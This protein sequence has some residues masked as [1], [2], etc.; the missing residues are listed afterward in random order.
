LHQA[1]EAKE[2]VVIERESQTYAS[3]TFQNY[4]RMY[5]KIAGM[6]GTGATSE[7]EF[8]SVYNLDVV[9]I[10][11][12]RAIARI[13]HDDLIFQTEAGKFKAI[14]R[15][16]KEKFEKG[17]PVL[18]GTTSIEVN[19]RLSAALRAAGVTHEMLNAKNH[20]REGE[21]IAQAGKMKGV[22][23]ATNMAGRGVDV[24]LGGNPAPEAL[25]EGVKEKGGLF[26]IGTER[27]DARRID[28]QLRGRAG[29]QGDPGETQFFVSLE[30]KLMRMFAAETVKGMMGRLGIPEDEPIQS[31]LV[32]R[33]LESAQEKIE[34]V[35]FD[36]RKHILGFDDVLNH[37][38]TIIY[39]KR[40]AVL[41][42]SYEEIIATATE[43]LTSAGVDP[44]IIV[45]KEEELGREVF[46]TQLR[47][48]LLQ[49]YDLFW[50]EHLETMEYLRGSVNLR[51][52]GGRDPFIEYR[53]EGLRLFRELETSLATFVADAI[54]RMAPQSAAPQS[55]GVVVV[56]S[57]A[58]RYSRNDHVTI[59]NGTETKELK[60]KKAEEFLSKGWRI[61]A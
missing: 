51:S 22:T 15:T 16:A 41:S 55:T 2:G 6:T 28:N 39:A 23:V 52:F 19:E 7:E 27:H 47:R 21:I 9:V 37:Q 10:P 60:Y 53:R 3:I 34:G 57:G 59:T 54:G 20:E 43:H 33:S 26:V 49:A 56:P 25:Y 17:Q 61:V 24:K 58:K 11:T 48:S 45:K 5:E 8:R 14:V 42:G 46:I 18:I 31:R 38:R 4:F 32:S 13:D 44:D 1:I 40:R 35:N 30:D 29:R 12:H 36:S 50:I